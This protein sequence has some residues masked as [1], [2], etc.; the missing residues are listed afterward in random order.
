MFWAKRVAFAIIV[1]ASQLLLI[2]LAVGWCVNL[3]LIA[4]HGEVYFVEPK[5]LIL[6][7]EMAATV[8]IIL[9]GIAVFAFQ[10]KKLTERRRYDDAKK[11][12][13]G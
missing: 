2:G 4:K 1:L 11:G 7:A 5:P 10:C 3:V 8:F 9:F 13:Q 12:S 6:Y